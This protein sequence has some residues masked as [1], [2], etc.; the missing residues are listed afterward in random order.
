MSNINNIEWLK[1]EYKK[2]CEKAEILRKAIIVL[3]E[4][5]EREKPGFKRTIKIAETS[6]PANNQKYPDKRMKTTDAIRWAFNNKPD[7]TW[8]LIELRRFLVDLNKKGLLKTKAGDLFKAI[9]SP[10]RRLHMNGF[11]ERIGSKR[12]KNVR[13]RK[14]E[15]L[16]IEHIHLDDL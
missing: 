13:Y 7:K 1:S 15:V 6:L 8:K 4:N 2:L 12:K 16:E 10:I 14:K 5:G 11:I 9:G 3:S